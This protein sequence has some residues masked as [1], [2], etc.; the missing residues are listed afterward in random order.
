M[1]YAN[2]LRYFII[3]LSLLLLGITSNNAWAETT[4][5]PA[6]TAAS[7]VEQL[8]QQAVQLHQAGQLD[9]ALA[10][11]TRVI[12]QDRRHANAYLGRAQIYDA[13]Q[14]YDL[15]IA[16]LRQVIALNPENADAYGVLGWILIREGRFDEARTLTQKANELDPGAFAW[17]INLGHLYL[18]AGDEETA[19]RYYLKGLD[20]IETEQQF[21]EGPV[22]DFKLFIE[23]GW[24]V[25]GMQQELGWIKQA[26]APR[27]RWRSLNQEVM[28]HYRAGDYGKAGALA[29]EAL[30]IAENTF[31]TDH[32]NTARSLN[33][34]AVVLRDQGRYGEAELLHRQALAIGQKVL[35]AEHPN[36]AA[37]LNNLAAVLDAQGRYGE[38]EPL[39]R[40]ALAIVEKVLGAEHPDTALSLN[41]LAAVLDDQGR[42][43]EAE[44]LY[45][46]AL[47]IV[48]KVL[49]AEHPNT[50]TSLNNLAQVLRAQ[51]RYGEAEPLHRQALAIR[52]KV[53]GAEHPDTATS[54]NNL[55]GVLQDQGRYGEAEPLYRQ[56]LAIQQKVLGTEHPDT[57][58][59]L[60]NLAAVLKDQ[61]RYGE[62]E[63]TLP[64][65]PGDSAESAGHRA[66]RYR[67][68]SQRFG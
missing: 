4:T 64:P 19:R 6:E 24:H 30:A 68:Q 23:K 60:N 25:E 55:A 29:R 59:S 38:A 51:S 61:G 47:A 17:A 34:L 16:D 62:A 31:G 46:Q 1:G 12:E 15:A 20:R 3:V 28:A 53:L 44:P 8:Y 41:N 40:Q 43:G 67:H 5:P 33:N 48:E 27:Q 36:T 63:T 13:Q 58:T 26:Y 35:G 45:R 22:A 21:E 39:H 66:S 54:L 42:T 65:S 57:A 49:G 18:L 56:A 52:Q 9:Q 7:P 37:S 2:L 32:P 10:A 50:A 11:Y 14:Q